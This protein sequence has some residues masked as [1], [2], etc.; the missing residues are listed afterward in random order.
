MIIF[1]QLLFGQFLIRIFFSFF[2][3]SIEGRK[4]TKE[5]KKNKKLRRFGYAEKN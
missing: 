5:Q 2:F 3:V 4:P 1:V